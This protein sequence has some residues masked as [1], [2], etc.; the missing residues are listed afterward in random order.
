MF[1]FNFFDAQV[2]QLHYSRCYLIVNVKLKN[3]IG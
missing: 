1:L 2:I 3:N